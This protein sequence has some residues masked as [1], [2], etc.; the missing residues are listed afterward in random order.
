[1]D[2]INAESAKVLFSRAQKMKQVKE[3][4]MVDLKTQYERLKSEI[5]AGIADVINTTQ[6]IKG[7][8]VKKFEENL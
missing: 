6:F 4:K 1:M 3:I 2:A 7:P 5:D 8:Q